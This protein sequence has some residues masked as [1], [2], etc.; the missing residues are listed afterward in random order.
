LEII[1]RSWRSGLA[2]RGKVLSVLIVWWL[3]LVVFISTGLTE[4][5]LELPLSDS[6]LDFYFARRRIYPLVNDL[7]ATLLSLSPPPFLVEV[8]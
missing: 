6:L 2:S 7:G 4:A 1:L 5:F 8:G 3:M